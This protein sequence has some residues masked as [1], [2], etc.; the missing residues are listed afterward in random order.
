MSS[1][2]PLLDDRGRGTVLCALDE[3]D[4]PGGKAIRVKGRKEM[5]VVRWQGTVGGYVNS[6]PH[7]GVSL[8]WNP[9]QF[10]NYERTLI[11]CSMHYALFR[12]E[13]GVCVHG[14]CAGKSLAPVRVRV[15]NGR[16]MLD[17]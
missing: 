7:T 17:E 15:E 12:P 11:M 14:P 4:E 13:D 8:D 16:V 9:D 10:F 3:I 6:C 5:F 2:P 1:L